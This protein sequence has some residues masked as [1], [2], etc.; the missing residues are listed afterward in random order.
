MSDTGRV[1]DAV[2]RTGH[3]C[4]FCTMFPASRKTARELLHSLL[5][6][7]EEIMGISL[8]FVQQKT[9]AYEDK[10]RMLSGLF[11]HTREQMLILVELPINRTHTMY[12]E[13][14]AIASR[15]ETTYTE[16]MFIA[17]YGS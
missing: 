12:P 17:V 9:S 5:V 2:V 10:D 6:K 1:L 13:L 15:L 8:G 11:H 14:V 4:F 3:L 7:S 16:T